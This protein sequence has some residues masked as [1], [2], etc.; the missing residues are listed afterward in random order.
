VGADGAGFE[1]RSHQETPIAQSRKAPAC[2]NA[3]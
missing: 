3:V 2:C 1:Q